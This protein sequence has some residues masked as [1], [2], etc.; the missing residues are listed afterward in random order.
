[1]SKLIKDVIKDSKCRIANSEKEIKRAM[2]LKIDYPD[3]SMEY[4]NFSVKSL[5]GAMA[6]HNDIVDLI[7]EYRD[8]HMEVPKTMLELWDFEHT[9]LIE[10]VSDIKILQEHYKK[11]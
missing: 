1:M 11:M 3:L 9:E 6:L 8:S 7:E 5:D 4:Y 2:E 10:E